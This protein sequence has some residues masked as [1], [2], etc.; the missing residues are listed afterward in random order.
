MSRN[1]I[2]LVTI[3]IMLSLFLAAMEAT[4]VATAMPTIV[5]QLGGLEHYSWVFSA[6]M[7]TSTTTVPLYGK[8]SDLYGRRKLYIFAMG[9]FLV[10]SILCGQSNSMTQLVF[11]R[12]LQG[13]GAGGIMPLA[14]ILIGEMFTLEERAKMQGFFSGVWGVSSII[15]PLLGGF[16]VDQLSWHWVFY[17]NIPPGLLGAALVAFAWRDQ[18]HGHARPAVDYAGAALLTA[19]VVALLLG[20]VE[21]GT[22]TSWTLIAASIVLFILLLWV[23]SRATDPILPIPLFRDRLFTTSITHGILAGWALFGSLSFIPLFVQSVLGTNATQA[24]ITIAPM[25]LGWVTASIIGTRFLLKIGYRRLAIT[26]TALLAIG[27][28]LMSRA[29]ANTTRTMLMVFVSLMGTGMGFSIPPFLIAV[30]TTVERRQLG[31]ATSTM[32]FSR[33][34]G[35]TLGVSVMGAALSARLAS[36]ISA[37][38]LDPKLVSQLLDPLPGAQAV[39]NEGARIAVADAITVVFVLAFV[40]AGL[41]LLATLFT[42]RKELRERTTESEPM[43]IS[44]D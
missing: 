5:G 42:P 6:Y 36:N 32:Q 8:L 18:V 13:L 37:S 40:A 28:F 33:S 29:D 22:S 21:F 25:L 20:L 10:G 31:T 34:I 4:V 27:T 12:A 30:Q 35:G 14:F 43:L 39:I 44:A 2:N 24:G 15:G 9:L 7:L 26:G 3:G 11:A 19:S 23:E 41:A 17:I 38:G 1:R 16:L